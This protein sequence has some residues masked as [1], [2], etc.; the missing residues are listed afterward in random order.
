MIVVAELTSWIKI[1]RNI[2]NW[3]W[4]KTS[5]ITL[6]VFLYLL[7]KA[8]VK[9]GE[10]GSI[11]VLRGQ[12][13]TSYTKIAEDLNISIQQVRTSINH[14]KSTGEITVSTTN[15]Y[16]I[17]TVVNYSRYQGESS[18]RSTGR[19]RTGKQQTAERKKEEKPKK[20]KKE[21]DEYSPQ[22]WEL[23]IP[24]QAWGK[25][26]TVEE[27]DIWKEENIDEVSKWLMN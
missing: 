11:H 13:V 5:H 2:I 17:I 4:F 16:S 14:L 18:G 26:K 20:E 24:K 1:D 8:N 12:L 27:W 25:F 23:D 3:R 21:S 22:F 7:I 10:F 6:T 15:R 19:K 9:A